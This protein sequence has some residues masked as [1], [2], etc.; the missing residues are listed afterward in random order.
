MEHQKKIVPRMTGTKTTVEASHFEA[1]STRIECSCFELSFRMSYVV[2]CL[3][4]VTKSQKKKEQS[5]LVLT[6][7]RNC[8]ETK[9]LPQIVKMI[10]RKFFFSDR[11]VFAKHNQNLYF[12]LLVSFSSF[13]ILPAISVATTR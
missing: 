9:S 4:D 6:R 5:C 13:F 8:V 11:V 7:R 3:F 10:N 2:V 1:K 12:F